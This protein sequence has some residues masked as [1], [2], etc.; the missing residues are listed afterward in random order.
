V[1]SFMT[2][3]RAAIP[4]YEL[5]HNSIWY[6]RP[7]RASDVSVQ[8]QIAA[9]DVINL[10]GGFASDGGL[11][12]GTG[13]WSVSAKMEFVDAVHAAHRWVVVDD[14]PSTNA[15]REYA[16]ACYLLVNSGRDA[17]GDASMAP[18]TWW[19][20]YDVR[21][22][23]ALGART[24]DASGLFRREF[25]RGLVLMLEPSAAARTVALPSPH[26]TI[27]GASV[28]EIALSAKQGAVLTRN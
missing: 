13:E 8:Q 7:A 6:A 17:L 28:T 23:K 21:L 24:R 14:F 1:A 10:E 20:G 3:V 5:L 19:T 27:A 4:Q 22:G 9:A 11:T 12:G 2:E 15:E 25:E 16:L 18:S 26:V